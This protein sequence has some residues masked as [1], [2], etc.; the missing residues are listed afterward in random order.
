L[1]RKKRFSRNPAVKEREEKPVRLQTTWTPEYTIHPVLMSK[2]AALTE[3][4]QIVLAALV[5]VWKPGY[6]PVLSS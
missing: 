5:A 4:K 6:C 2:W 3:V 1:K